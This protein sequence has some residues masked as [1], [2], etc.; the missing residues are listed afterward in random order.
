M[1]GRHTDTEASSSSHVSS[2]GLIDGKISKKT[3]ISD[4]LGN[5]LAIA[6]ALAATD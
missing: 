5:V 3:I 4:K 1:E 2:L 6:A